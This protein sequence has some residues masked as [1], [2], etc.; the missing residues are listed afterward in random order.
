MPAASI[1]AASDLF[2]ISPANLFGNFRD[3]PKTFR[4]V[5]KNFRDVSKKKSVFRSC[6]MSL[7]K[8]IADSQ[9]KFTAQRYRLKSRNKAIG[10]FLLK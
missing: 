8:N 4:D 2:N 6:S 5:P 3:V 1:A 9:R 10:R 7:H